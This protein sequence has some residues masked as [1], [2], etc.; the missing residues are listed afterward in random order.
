MQ[1]FPPAPV[2]ADV[3][4]HKIKGKGKQK[5]PAQQVLKGNA[6]GKGQHKGMDRK[7]WATVNSASNGRW[8]CKKFNDN[9]GCRTPCVEG[10]YHA[11]DCELT[12]G[13]GC[14]QTGHN[15]QNHSAQHNG[16]AK[17]SR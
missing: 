14:E 13:Y 15:R 4:Q 11:C 2:F 8:L 16:A 10:G 17:V 7:K 3:S 6:K 12:N 9:R 1:W 5:A